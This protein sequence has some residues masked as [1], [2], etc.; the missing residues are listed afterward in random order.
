MK[1]SEE[2]LCQVYI[3]G[4]L[5]DFCVEVKP[6]SFPGTTMGDAWHRFERNDLKYSTLTIDQELKLLEIAIHGYARTIDNLSWAAI[7]K[8]KNALKKAFLEDLAK[9]REE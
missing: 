5:C 9:Q 4:C 3:P 1:R 6:V 7:V 2:K 8:D